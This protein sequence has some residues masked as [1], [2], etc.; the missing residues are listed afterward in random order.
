MHLPH[1]VWHLPKASA[2]KRLVLVSSL[3]ST[4]ILQ[5]PQILRALPVRDVI[6]NL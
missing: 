6:R 4:N 2:S 5:T 3:N 1:L